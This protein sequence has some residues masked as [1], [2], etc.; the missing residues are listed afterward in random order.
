[1][2]LDQHETKAAKSFSFNNLIS[3]LK[4]VNGI[5]KIVLIIL[6][7]VL[8]VIFS[9]YF[10]PKDSSINGDNYNT[11]IPSQSFVINMENRLQKLL[12]NMKGVSNVNVLVYVKSS[13][14]IVYLKDTENI[15]NS[16]TNQT[17]KETTVFNK[18]GSSTSAVVVVT[19]YPTI[20]GI[21]IVASGVNDVKVKMKIIDAVS[22][23]LSIAPKNIEVLEG[24]S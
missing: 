19:K 16:S 1:M 9:G 6:A 17:L 10:F 2:Q 18:D 13:E 7:L 15:A 8:I 24:K 21:L 3:N 4:S 11:I 22:C 5:K 20:E 23:V 12:S 14:E